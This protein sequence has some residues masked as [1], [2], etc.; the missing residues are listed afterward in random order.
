MNNRFNQI[1]LTLLLVWVPLAFFV[2]AADGFTL[3][4]ELV[5]LLAVV[6]FMVLTLMKGTAVY[7]QPLVITT[8]L[9]TLWMVA[10]SYGVSL[11]KA[12]V[13]PGSFHLWLI[14]GTLVAVVFACSKGLSYE[15]L[16]HWAV[17]TGSFMAL[18]GFVQV[19][20]MDRY[21]WTTRFE[22]RAFATLGNPDYLGG[23]L[24]ALVPLAFVLTLRT[25]GQLPFDFKKRVPANPSQKAWFWLRFFTLLMFAGLLLTKVKGSFIALAIVMVFMGIA[26]LFPAGRE[27]FRQNKRYVLITLSLLVAGAGFYLYRHGGLESFGAKQVSVE[28]RINN[29]KVA[30]AIVQ[31]HFWTGVGLGQV[32]VQYPKYQAVP[33]TPAEYPE[34]PYTYSE[35]VHNDFLQFWVEGGLIGLVLFLG[36]LAVYGWNVFHFFKNPGIR[37]ENKELLLAVLAAMT[38]LLAQSLSNFPLLVAPTAVLFGLFLAA[39]LALRPPVSTHAAFKLSIS[40]QAI[41]ALSL[42][43]FLT[44]GLQSL[45]ASIAI[46]NTRGETNLG[47]ADMAVYFGKRLTA[48]SPQDPKAW[49]ALGAALALDGKNDEACDAYQKS[50]DLNPNFVENLSAMGNIRVSQ[51]RFT[52]ALV[53]SERGLA[54]TPNYAVLLW[55]RGVSLFQFKRYEESAKSFETFL[56]YAPNDSQTYL[57]LG[58]CYIQLNRKEDAINAWKKSYQ[59]GPENQQALVYLKSQ[60][61]VLK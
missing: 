58:V 6:Y 41:L 47:K 14:L 4:K 2:R 37:K 30:W 34:H 52:E 9:F 44:L 28:Q 1:L 5:G 11:V 51:G 22:T 26:F 59:L 36:V 24:V 15:R 46:R 42:L 40:Q 55:V 43:V 19:L 13:L 57:N 10:D 32:G 48:L 53:L 56:T 16:L 39:P 50:A 54:I 17:A 38:A 21:N 18:Y 25:Y 27:L 61:V 3:A 29:Y 31:D 20:G 23:Y 49:N 60:G 8:I 45:A 7:R 35:H 33:Y 12:Y